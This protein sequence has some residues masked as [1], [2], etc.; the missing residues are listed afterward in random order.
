[1]SAGT[2]E[3]VATTSRWRPTSRTPSLVFNSSSAA[4]MASRIFCFTV[5]IVIY[6]WGPP[7]RDH[8]TMTPHSLSPNARLASKPADPFDPN[9]PFAPFAR[10]DPF[11]PNEQDFAEA[12]EANEEVNRAILEIRGMGKR[13][14]ALERD[15]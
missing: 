15:E 13:V 8:R 1:M 14:G 3:E 9:D 10:L 7:P 2:S 5:G 11:D 6:N 12:N 4:K